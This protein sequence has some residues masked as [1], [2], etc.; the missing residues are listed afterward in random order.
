MLS[1]ACSFLFYPEDPLGVTGPPSC[2]CL[3]GRDEANQG[4]ALCEVL[5]FGTEL[6]GPQ[7][8]GG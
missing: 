7:R 2:Q 4:L 1:P 8:V 5:A 3:R 6:E